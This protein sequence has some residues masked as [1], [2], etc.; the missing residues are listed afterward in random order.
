MLY[1]RWGEDVVVFVR[2]SGATHWLNPALAV[3]LD[4]LRAADRALSEL[5]LAAELELAG[6]DDAADLRSC[7]IELEALGL[8]TRAPGRPAG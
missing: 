6:A 2:C 8:V 5:Q 3:I 4:R 1:H 7:L